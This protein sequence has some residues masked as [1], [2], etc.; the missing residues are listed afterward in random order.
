LAEEL[1]QIQAS[2]VPMRRFAPLRTHRLIQIYHSCICSEGW[3]SSVVADPLR[4]R[5]R[6]RPPLIRRFRHPAYGQLI[7]ENAGTGTFLS[8]AMSIST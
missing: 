7:F 5:Q 3:H 6:N 8:I 4:Q 1:G 2:R